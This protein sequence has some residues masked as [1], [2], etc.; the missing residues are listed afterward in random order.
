M[1]FFS[2]V[3]V[4]EVLILPGFRG[5]RRGC[6]PPGSRLV[7]LEG[8]AEGALGFFVLVALPG[9]LTMVAILSRLYDV[10]WVVGYQCSR[11]MYGFIACPRRGVSSM[12]VADHQHADPYHVIL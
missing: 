4:S 12:P 6:D 8:D 5:G 9:G 2:M 11:C 7:A 1:A 3:V 10:S